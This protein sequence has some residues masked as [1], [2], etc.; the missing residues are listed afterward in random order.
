MLLQPFFRPFYGPVPVFQRLCLLDFPA[1]DVGNGRAKAEVFPCQ[2]LQSARGRIRKSPV[3]TGQR[4]RFLG[5]HSE[6]DYTIV[7]I[8]D[9]GVVINYMH[10][11]G[12][13][14]D[15]RGTV[16]LPYKQADP[17]KLRQLEESRRDY[18]RHRAS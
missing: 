18:D 3:S 13:P 14:S 6:T 15:G 11:G 8:E 4:F 5:Q 2:G 1:Q 16:K 17:E 12:W 10:S 7:S 9:D